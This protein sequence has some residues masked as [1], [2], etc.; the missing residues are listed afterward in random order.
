MMNSVEHTVAPITAAVTIRRGTRDGQLVSS[1]RSPQSS[2]PKQT[3]KYIEAVHNENLSAAFHITLISAFLT[4][5]NPSFVNAIQVFT[6]KRSVV[7]VAPPMV[8]KSFIGTIRT[9]C[10]SIATFRPGIASW[11]IGG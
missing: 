5:A 10:I 11:L 1:E 4:I 7:R 8:A 6:E 3:L 9:E 2:V